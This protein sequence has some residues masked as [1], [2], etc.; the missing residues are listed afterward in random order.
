MGL[1]SISV[2]LLNPKNQQRNMVSLSSSHQEVLRKIFVVFSSGFIGSLVG[3]HSPN[4]DGTTSG[5]ISHWHTRT[6]IDPNQ[7]PVAKNV[8]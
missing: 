5:L 7:L 8:G 2:D 4:I 1:S 3:L 6:A